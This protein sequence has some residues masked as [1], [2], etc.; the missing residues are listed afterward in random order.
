MPIVQFAPHSSLVNPSFWH[1]LTEHKLDVLKL[2]DAEVPVAASYGTGRLI[3][4]REG[5]AFIGVNG[6]FGV[7]EESFANGPK[8]AAFLVPA[9]GHLKNY[10]TIEEFKAADKHELFNQA[11]EKVRGI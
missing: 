3:K 11:A 4:D 10:N 9:N 1:K 6:T 2:S 7:D 5:G 8:P